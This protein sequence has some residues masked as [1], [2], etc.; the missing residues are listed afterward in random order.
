[1]L[2]EMS[3]PVFKEKGVVRPPIVFK[4][5]LNVVLGKEDGTNSIGKSSALLAIDFAF[6]GNTY[7]ASDGVKHIGDHTIFFTFMFDGESYYFARNTAAAEEIQVCSKGYKLTGIV[8]TRHEFTD[9]LKEKYRIDF[10]GLS[11]RATLS[12]FFRIYGKENTNERKPLYGNPGDGMQK[13]IDRLVK[14]FN[15]YG[16]IE[17]YTGRLEEQKKKLT[18]Y[19]EA[20]RY[21]FV[22]DLVGGKDQYD[23]NVAEI[24]S[25]QMELDTLTSEQ[26]E[27]HSE[28]DIEKNKIKSDLKDK[29]F[30]LEETIEAKKRR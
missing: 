27:T 29:R 28:E 2:K 15:R 5:G 10:S 17:D 7:I 4:E 11:F 22:S 23:S 13:S 19:R 3:S 8:W 6:G 14:L 18:A 16:E 24:C 25:L 1:M 26:V 21:R 9:W 30:R 20:R 12:S